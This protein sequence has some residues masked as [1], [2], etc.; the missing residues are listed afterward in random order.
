MKIGYAAADSSSVSFLALAQMRRRHLADRRE[1]ARYQAAGAALVKARDRWDDEDRLAAL[2]A[3]TLSPAE[4]LEVALDALMAG[5]P[6]TTAEERETLRENLRDA[7]RVVAIRWLAW[8]GSEWAETMEV[9]AA[10]YEVSPEWAPAVEPLPARRRAHGPYP[11][12]QFEEAYT[13]L[14]PVLRANRRVFSSG[15]FDMMAEA[16]TAQI[17]ALAPSLAAR[18]VPLFTQYL[19]AC[20]NAFYADPANGAR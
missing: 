1:Q 2:L 14:F 16:G 12:N 20:D 8:V 13:R 10:P 19:Q 9:A 4:Q 17:E 6:E 18:L 15:S 3:V 11:H 7:T 5:R